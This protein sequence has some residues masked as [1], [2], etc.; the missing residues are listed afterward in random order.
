MMLNPNLNK[1]CVH[2]LNS[3]LD[4]NGVDKE[5]KSIVVHNLGE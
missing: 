5:V 4:K 2:L 3:N 1:K